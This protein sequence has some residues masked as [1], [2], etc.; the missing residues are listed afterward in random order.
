M[1]EYRIKSSTAH[2]EHELNFNK[3]I[4]IASAFSFLTAFS[5]FA[6]LAGYTSSTVPMT[7]T[8]AT[9][10]FSQFSDFSFELPQ[11]AAAHE[12]QVSFFLKRWRINRT[13]LNSRWHCGPAFEA[14]FLL[15]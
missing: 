13:G 12:L 10:D 2:T 11:T 15:Y 4:D 8:T 7:M 5:S 1:L 9:I 14:S 6:A 3:T